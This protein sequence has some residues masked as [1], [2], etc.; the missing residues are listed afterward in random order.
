[1]PP[2]KNTGRPFQRINILGNVTATTSRIVGHEQTCKA[3]KQPGDRFAGPSI[4]IVDDFDSAVTLQR[5]G[6]HCPY[7][8]TSAR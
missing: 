3:F 4:R 1:M 6:P 8:R 7:V 2:L 5:Q